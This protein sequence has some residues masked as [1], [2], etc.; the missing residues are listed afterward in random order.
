MAHSIYVRVASNAHS[1]LKTLFDCNTARSLRS[2]EA[3]PILRKGQ[4]CYLLSF[5]PNIAHSWMKCHS[6]QAQGPK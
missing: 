5:I 6:S 1:L 2:K 3:I 4:V